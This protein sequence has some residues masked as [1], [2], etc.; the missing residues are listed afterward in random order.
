[1]PS[2]PYKY[3]E[4]E[5]LRLAEFIL[6]KGC[7]FVVNEPR[8]S[9]DMMIYIRDYDEMVRNWEWLKIDPRHYLILRD[10]YVECPL[11]HFSFVTKEG[12][13]MYSILQHY[14]GPYIDLLYFPSPQSGDI[15]HYSYFYYEKVD[16]YQIKPPE[17][18]VLL[19]KEICKYIRQTTCVVKYYNRKKY[20]GP[21]YLI[22]VI[23][24]KVEYV[25]DE[26]RKLVLE[27][28]Q[29]HAFDKKMKQ[30]L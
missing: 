29:E 2:L 19:Y 7:Y 26:F 27:L 20:C 16:Y 10:D 30:L 24:N 21:E 18:M 28:H 11:F 23:D 15:D 17:A 12:Q 13:T 5:F 22:N 9:P 6:S 1:M 25:D 14:G 4:K 3:S 8:E